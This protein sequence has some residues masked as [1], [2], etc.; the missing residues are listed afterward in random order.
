MAATISS[1]FSLFVPHQHDCFR[2]V[3]A[4]VHN[5]ASFAT[6]LK[7]MFH[8]TFQQ[9]YSATYIFPWLLLRTAIGVARSRNLQLITVLLYEDCTFFIT[10]I[11]VGRYALVKGTPM[12]AYV[13]CRCSSC[14]HHS[15]VLV[16]GH[17]QWGSHLWCFVAA[18]RHHK[19]K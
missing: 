7:A 13:F 15:M 11:F 3:R 18:A 2:S 16:L 1:Y 14:K 19:C 9:C 4:A 10:R 12:A 6:L 8:T 17:R 5:T